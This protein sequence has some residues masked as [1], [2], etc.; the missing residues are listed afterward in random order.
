MRAGMVGI[1]SKL[2]YC[3]KVA[4]LIRLKLMWDSVMLLL[5]YYI[6]I[7]KYILLK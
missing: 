5:V 3:V 4:E 1:L 7:R 2:H 6:F